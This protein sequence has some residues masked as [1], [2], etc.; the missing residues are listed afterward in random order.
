M[1]SPIS[2]RGTAAC[3]GKSTGG[4]SRR[5]GRR[6]ARCRR[7]SRAAACSIRAAASAGRPMMLLVIAQRQAPHRAH[8]HVF[9]E[10]RAPV[11]P[12]SHCSTKTGRWPMDQNV[13]E[14]T[15][16]TSAWAAMASARLVTASNMR[17]SWSFR[18]SVPARAD[19]AIVSQICNNVAR[20]RHCDFCTRAA[21]RRCRTPARRSC[22]C[23]SGDS[24]DRISR[25]SPPAAARRR[26]RHRP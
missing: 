21:I 10:G 4:L 5:N 7:M 18:R 1:T 8:R 3:P 22:R 17:M 11:R 14:T 20:N 15:P 24:R 6:S 2:S 16:T 19:V 26:P 23:V 13:V 25:R 12:F 9:F